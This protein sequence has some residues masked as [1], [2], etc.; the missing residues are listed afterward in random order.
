MRFVRLVAFCTLVLA[1]SLGWGQK[2]ITLGKLGQAI[3]ETSIHASPSK[4]ARVYYKVRAFEYLIIQ[5]AKQE[6]WLRVLLEN[7]KFGYIPAAKVAR[8]PYDVTQDQTRKPSPP[9][10]RSVGGGGNR[11]ALAGYSLNFVGTPYVWGGNDIQNGV[12]CSG[13]VKALYGKIGINLPRTAAEQ[14]LVGQPI[15]R[16]EDLRPGDRLYFW[17]AKRNKIGHTGIYLGGGYFCHSSTSR[18]AVGTDSLVSGYYR[19]NLV[20]ARR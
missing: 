18:G 4:S 13:F 19:N 8:L 17:S 14:A 3:E 10:S 12:D 9:T 1:G 2:K 7:G 15:Y 20:A 11:E 6:N 16:L 5:S